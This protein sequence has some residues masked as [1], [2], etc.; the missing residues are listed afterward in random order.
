MSKRNRIIVIIMTSVVLIFGIFLTYQYIQSQK[1]IMPDTIKPGENEYQLGKYFLEEEGLSLLY[2]LMERT[3]ELPPQANIDYMIIEVKNSGKVK[4]FDILLS[5][6]DN[7]GIYQGDIRYTYDEDSLVFSP[8][9]EDDLF[10]YEYNVNFEVGNLSHQV[11]KI[12]LGKQLPKLN[13]NENFIG[14]K[15]PTNVPEG[16]PIFDGRENNTFPVLSEV[17]YQDGIGGVSDGNTSVVFQLYDGTRSGV[18][19]GQTY[20][21]VCSP[22][23]EET[24]VGNQETVME[25]DYYIN[26]TLFLTRDYG[27]SWIETD[28]TEDE[29]N[30][31]LAFYKDISLPPKSVYIS[32]DKTM[33]LAFFYEENA[34][35]SISRDNGETWESQVLDDFDASNMNSFKP[36]M[37]RSVGFA[38]PSFGYV[39]LGTEYTPATGEAKMALFTTDGGETW[40]EKSLP[41]N[42][43]SSVLMNLYMMDESQGIVALKDGM[44]GLYSKLYTTTDMGNSWGEITLP[45]GELPSEITFLSYVSELSFENGRYVLTMDQGNWGRIRVRFVSEDIKGPWVYESHEEKPIHTVG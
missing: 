18:L 38:T 44:D 29:M 4:N 45:L 42:N 39:A 11:M 8:L 21:Y 33:P 43:S 22:R 34:T 30:E 25:C 35:L 15:T 37:F 7:E 9:K 26:A 24:A 40:I 1:L 12:P 27:A 17:E 10:A 31:T 14:L 2:D 32:T 6:Y 13:F 19:E 28:I 20:Y 3:E 23:D 5:T 36:Y 41:L 16:T